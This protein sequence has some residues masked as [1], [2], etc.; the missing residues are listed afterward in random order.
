[1]FDIFIMQN[2]INLL[3]LVQKSYF[4]SWLSGWKGKQSLEN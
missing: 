4:T 2:Q 1:M 3:I